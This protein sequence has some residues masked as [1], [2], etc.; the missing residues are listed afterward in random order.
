MLTSKSPLT[1]IIGFLCG[2]IISPTVQFLLL[3]GGVGYFIGQILDN[4]DVK[5][6]IDTFNFNSIHA[7]QDIFHPEDIPEAIIIYSRIDNLTTVLIDFRVDSKPQDFRLFVLK[8]LQEFEF[9]VMEDANKTTI[10]LILE[11]PNCNYPEISTIVEQKKVMHFDII[12]RSKDFL[13]AVQKI[14]PGLNLVT[15]AYPDLYV[16][17][18]IKDVIKPSNSDFQFPP[19][20]PIMKPKF[21][22]NTNLSTVATRINSPSPTINSTSTINRD[23][24]HQ[25]LI[26]YPPVPEKNSDDEINDISSNDDENDDLN[27]ETIMKDLIS[28]SNEQR[29]SLNVPN[30]TPDDVKNLKDMNVRAFNNFLDENDSENTLHPLTKANKLENTIQDQSS[31][32]NNEKEEIEESSE[33]HIDYSNTQKSQEDTSI[34]DDFSFKFIDQLKRGKIKKEL[35]LEIQEEVTTLREAFKDK[36]TSKNSAS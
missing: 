16:D 27:D 25:P 36:K 6:Q 13:S 26:D 10:N 15:T 5:N 30:L 3:C 11:Y 1:T 17:L 29:E 22:H 33:L 14:V 12:E 28:D 19:S 18:N 20:S 9:R 21:D 8:N 24:I 23:T 7:T 4:I 34:I 2:F 32:M 35:N 31:E